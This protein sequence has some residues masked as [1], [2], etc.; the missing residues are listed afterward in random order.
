MVSDR[1][2]TTGASCLHGA[3]ERSL[4]AAARSLKEGTTGL[5]NGDTF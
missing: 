4:S 2:R 1:Q 3:S 5:V